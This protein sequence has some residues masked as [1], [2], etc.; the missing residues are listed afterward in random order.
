MKLLM[1]F[2]IFRMAFHDQLLKFQSNLSISKNKILF[3]YT[4]THTH[5]PTLQE[6]LRLL[7][8]RLSKSLLSTRNT[9]EV[10]C[11]IK[12][13]RCPCF[14]SLVYASCPNTCACMLSCLSCVQLFVIL[15]TVDCQD[16]LSMKILQA[17]ILEWFA[18]LSSRGSFQIRDWSHVS[19]VFC[20][21]R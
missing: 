6:I 18:M 9:W 10:C 12:M 7:Y 2:L 1:F 19:Y 11:I 3:K 5:T 15:W 17:R 20:I 16:P 21:G 8:W 4:H 14:L 13:V